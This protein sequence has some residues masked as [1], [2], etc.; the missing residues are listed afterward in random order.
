MKAWQSGT[1]DHFAVLDYQVVWHRSSCTASKFA[2]LD[3][4]VLRRKYSLTRSL[5]T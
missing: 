5:S 2:G 3:T 4:V 1:V